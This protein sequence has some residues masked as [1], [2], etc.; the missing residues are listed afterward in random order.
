MRMEGFQEVTGNSYHTIPL[1][2]DKMLMKQDFH[3]AFKSDLAYIGTYLPEKRIFFSEHVLPLRQRYDLRIYGQD[4]TRSDRVLG[5][6]QKVGQYFNIHGLRTL[7]KPK[8]ELMDEARIYSSSKICINVHEQ[9]QKDFGGDCN[10]RTFKIPLCG[11]FEITDNVS[12]IRKY[13]REDEIV[14]AVDKKDWF[15]KI[16]FYMRLPE[17]RAKI[18]EKGK[19]RVLSDHTYHNRVIQII[20]IYQSIR[21]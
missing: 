8:L 1:A 7:L 15:E 5:F 11:G 10:E 12:A 6:A 20:N 4:W 2:A 19:R 13:F 3:E 17:Q 21:V 14:I 16:D 18:A 9:Y